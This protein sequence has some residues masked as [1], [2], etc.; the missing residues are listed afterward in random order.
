MDSE[1]EQ[2]SQATSI[3]TQQ[4]RGK[5]PDTAQQI[6]S[7]FAKLA[8]G[9]KEATAQK[10]EE[11]RER[12]RQAYQAGNF[13]ELPN[14]KRDFLAL[15]GE[16]DFDPTAPVTKTLDVIPEPT[17]DDFLG[18]KRLAF[19]QERTSIG[20]EYVQGNYNGKN[21]ILDSKGNIIVQV[22]ESETVTVDGQQI[23]VARVRD[24]A[25][26]SGA[27]LPDTSILLVGD[28]VFGTL[29]NPQSEI[30]AGYKARESIRMVLGHE[31]THVKFQILP[32]VE[33][34]QIVDYYAGQWGQIHDFATT[35]LSREDYRKVVLSATLKTLAKNPNAKVRPVVIEGKTFSVAVESVVSE[36]LAY[37]STNI[38]LGEQ[39]V[40]ELD[41][42]NPTK[43]QIHREHLSVKAGE[44]FSQLHKSNQTIPGQVL[45]NNLPNELIQIM[46]AVSKIAR[47]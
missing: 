11:Y 42:I 45:Y 26:F 5:S 38:L 18:E 12:I 1:S 25:D 10:V 16:A 19:L 34:Q 3:D 29:L 2:S 30:K 32:P 39:R 14:L 40:K 8:P 47:R 24:R 13:K 33:K 31:L 28:K 37:N 15:G 35:L 23:Q 27:T 21:Y 43:E 41:K 46:S 9:L 4:T 44:A 22:S 20:G 17:K 36:L 6:K 7:T